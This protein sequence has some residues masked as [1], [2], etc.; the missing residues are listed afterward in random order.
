MALKDIH[1]NL[2]RDDEL[3]PIA[4]WNDTDLAREAYEAYG[5]NRN[6][7]THDGKPM[8]QWVDVRQEIK[9]AWVAAVN[10]VMVART[11]ALA[12]KTIISDRAR[13]VNVKGWKPY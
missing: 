9:D 5:D 4:D 2:M 6:W 12:A 3:Q 1:L 11:L 13:G 8:P 7:Q 10:A